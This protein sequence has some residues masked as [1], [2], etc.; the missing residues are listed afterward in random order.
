MYLESRIY[1]FYLNHDKILR[2]LRNQTGFADVQVY[3]KTK[4]IDGIHGIG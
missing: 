2:N 4:Q 1:L 3:G